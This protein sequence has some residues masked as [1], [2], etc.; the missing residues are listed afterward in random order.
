MEKIFWKNTC[1]VFNMKAHSVVG[2]SVLNL[3]IIVIKK[4]LKKQEIE[5][6]K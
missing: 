5:N 1:A 6:V 4:N 2:I 3:P